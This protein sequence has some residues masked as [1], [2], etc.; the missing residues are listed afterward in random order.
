M[1]PH[2]I[3]IATLSLAPLAAISTL[4]GCEE[5]QPAPTPST[6]AKADDHA[7]DHDHG[8]DH[9]TAGTGG[10]HDAPIA[11][12]GGPVIALGEQ[13]IGSFS[14]RAT[15][16]E[17]QIVAG[18]DAP[19]DVTITAAADA[20]AKAVAVRFWIGT[21]DAKGSVKA[22]AEIENPA[23]PNRWH[24]HAEVPNPIPAGSKLW[25]EIEDDK[26]GTSVGSFDLKM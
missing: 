2:L 11:G 9:G 20:T 18:K 3:L 19:I 13:T 24:V 23:E 5:K 6:P 17:G 22:K 14:A 1:R 21:E 7:H 10:D 16:D 4:T 25:V 8:H 12:H 26:N 15:R